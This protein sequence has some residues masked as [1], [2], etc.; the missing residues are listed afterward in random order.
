MPSRV[1]EDVASLADAAARLL[2]AGDFPAGLR[3]CRTALA[4]A[5]GHADLLHMLGIALAQAQTPTSTAM[6]LKRATAT[7]SILAARHLA[8]VLNALGRRQ[9]EASAHRVVLRLD[10]ADIVAL[11]NLGAALLAS[12]RS[13]EALA[14]LRRAA[15][16]GPEVAEVDHNLAEALTGNRL[17]AEAL[18]FA[19]RS[20]AI[21]A[22]FP[23][24]LNGLGLALRRL[25]QPAGAIRNF[26]R[27]LE[28]RPDYAEA[29]NNLG[30]ALHLERRIG[31]AVIRYRRAAVLKPADAAPHMNLGNA[32]IDRGDVARGVAAYRR[33]LAIDPD[34]AVCDTALIFAL[35]LAPG[36]GSG[37]QQAERRRWSRRHAQAFAALQAPH[38]NDR[39]PDRRL[40]LGF[41]SADFRQHAAASIFGP[42][43]RRLDPGAFEI[44][45]YSRVVRED[46]VTASFRDIAH[47]WRSTL[48]LAPAELAGTI[49]GDGIDILIDLSGH[50]AGSRLL[51]FA[52]KPAPVQVTAWGHGTGTGI[53]AIDYFLADP[54]VVPAEMR[55]LF[56]EQIYDLPCFLTFEAP[57]D[58]PPVAAVDPGRRFTFG[59]FNR[60][61]K[62]SDETAAAWGR[63][64]AGVPGA[65]LLLKDPSLDD[66]GARAGMAARLARHGIGAPCL[67]MRG[68]TPRPAHLASFAEVDLALD[69]F[70]QNGGVSTFEAIHMGVP[71]VALLGTTLPGRSGA[72]ILTAV[73]LSEWVAPDVDRYVRLATAKAMDRAALAGL[74]LRLREQLFGSE[75][76]NPVRYTAAV[77]AAFRTM[78][79]RWCAS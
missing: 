76:G 70:P 31:E 78:W 68:R 63:I 55:P 5:P 20:L 37:A 39:N 53:P 16:L 18:R 12:G 64:L 72:S 57:A 46:D 17:H 59:S 34:N 77:T 28:L 4:Q 30:N 54:I 58:A 19:L 41:V 23:E 32:W 48:D 21:R 10:P 47:F 13:R 51:A 67:E 29:Q 61:S 3:A 26:L 36:V 71:V 50:S 24:A 6:L 38:A 25:D 15:A 8:G 65:R 11:A 74:R 45:C 60:A 22:A 2:Q 66:P 49:R 40:R 62:I 33:S 14:P 52:A 73:G 42:V 9:E 35:D 7:G 43:L 1:S 75:A 56:A 27:A 44:G 69:P 79:R